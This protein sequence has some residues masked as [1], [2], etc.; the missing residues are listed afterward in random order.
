MEEEKK[1][2][3]SEQDGK[4]NEAK[5]AQPANEAKGKEEEKKDETKK[6]SGFSKWWKGTKAKMDADILEGHIQ[7]AYA[8]AHRS[9]DV[10]AHEGG[11]FNGGSAIG[12]IVDGSLIYWGDKAVEEFAVVVDSKDN[13]AYYTGKS[14]PIDLTVK[15]E[16]TD[17]V[18]KGTKTTLDSN[19][20]E[21]DVVKAGKRYFLYKGPKAE[22]K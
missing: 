21:V 12:E 1:E 9:F 17:Y 10:Y 16:G 11:I 19:V 8:Q 20:E 6:D 14:E 13:K 5:D 2:V 18:R 4:G 3:V 15:F 22:K 7:N